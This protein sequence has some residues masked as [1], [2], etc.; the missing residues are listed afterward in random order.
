MQINLGNREEA[1]EN[2]VRVTFRCNFLDIDAGA[3]RKSIVS[4][5]TTARWVV[6]APRRPVNLLCKEFVRRQPGSVPKLHLN[7]IQASLLNASRFGGA[8]NPTDPEFRS[9]QAS[10]KPREEPDSTEAEED[11]VELSQVRSLALLSVDL[12]GGPVAC[13]MWLAIDPSLGGVG[14]EHYWHLV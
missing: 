9:R 10:P 6:G 13:W 4:H 12:V 14:S 3:T 5:A 2:P 11:N 1:D 8:P 7:Q